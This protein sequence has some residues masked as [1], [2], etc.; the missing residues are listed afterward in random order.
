MPRAIDLWM[1]LRNRLEP[2]ERAA[3]FID[4]KKIMYYNKNTV[5]YL[6][7]K[8]VK[9]KETSASLYGQSLHYGLGV[10][11]GIRSY[12]TEDGPMI[13]KAREHFERL[14]YSARK[15][16]INLPYTVDELKELS[17]K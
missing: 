8:W 9:S 14:H 12:K 2:S 3:F 5:V 10:F 11:E 7:G 1:V 17:S 13:F 6:D 16:Q 15:M 4:K